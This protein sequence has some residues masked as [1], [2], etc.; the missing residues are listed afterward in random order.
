MIE[1]I[2]SGM[3]LDQLG[4]TDKRPPI[5]AAISWPDLAGEAPEGISE[6]SEA[7]LAAIGYCWQ[8]ERQ[9]LLRIAASKAPWTDEDVVSDA[10][11]MAYSVWRF[12]SYSDCSRY[13]AKTTLGLARNAA[14]RNRMVYDVADRPEQRES[15]LPDWSETSGEMSGLLQAI[16]SQ[17]VPLER[18]LIR[19]VLSPNGPST[20]DTAYWQT[21]ADMAGMS[22]SHCMT[23]LANLSKR[24][25]GNRSPVV[26]TG[27]WGR[28]GRNGDGLEFR[29]LT[30]LSALKAENWEE[31]MFGLTE[32]DLSRCVNCGGLSGDE[33]LCVRCTAKAEG[34]IHSRTVRMAGALFAEMVTEHTGETRH[35]VAV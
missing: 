15:M 2:E 12:K 18:K 21:I 26:E 9:R 19:M 34:L 16:Y 30:F 1:A 32:G 14:I 4:M 23:C 27:N 6:P 20:L 11:L 22:Y 3:A 5:S 25:L 24:Y 7:I 28:R 31:S 35:L 29:A 8:T 17:A 13:L 33:W 10:C